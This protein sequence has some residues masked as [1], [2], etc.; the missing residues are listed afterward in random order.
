MARITSK[1]QVTIPREVRRQMN[2]CEGDQIEFE[3]DCSGKFVL[4]K[5]N[6]APLSDGAAVKYMK[7][8]KVLSVAAMKEAARSGAIGSF[9]DRGL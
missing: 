1:H 5:R 6:R 8:K 7:R 9:Q 2:L 4:R 3:S